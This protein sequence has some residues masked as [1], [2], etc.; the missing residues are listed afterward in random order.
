MSALSTG[1]SKLLAGSAIA[2]A[3]I[4]AGLPQA[5]AT[6][7]SHGA[8]A[9]AA[10][11]RSANGQGTPA[12]DEASLPLKLER[13][14]LENGLRVV[15][16]PDDSSPN[17][18]LSVTY[19]VGSRNERPGLRGF[20]HLFEHLMFQGS[21][22]VQ[23]GD[24][25]RL[26]AAH[27]GRTGSNTT[28]ELT[29]L[30][31]VLPA[32]DLELGL[33]LEADRM[34]SLALSQ[35]KFDGQRRVVQE[36]YRSRV[37]NRAYETGRLRLYQ[38]AFQGYPP[39]ERPAIGAIEDLD[40]ATIAWVRSAFGNYYA[41]NN[42]VLT[43]AGRFD[44]ATAR[45][46]V[47]THFGDI[48]KKTIPEY[49]APPKPRQTSERLSVIEDANA[50]TPGVYYGWLIPPARTA[51]HLALEVASA[52]LARGEGSVLHE[53]LVL[54]KAMAEEISSWTTS[55]R[56]PSLFALRMIMT[57]R[58][59]IDTAQKQLDRELLRLRTRGPRP[60]ELARAKAL[61]SSAFLL[62]L[63]S[64]E[65][66]A[67]LL[68]EYETLWGD[69]RLLDHELERIDQVTADDVRSAA[70]RHLSE[71]QRTIVEVFPPGWT[72]DIFP[73][74]YDRVH[75]VEHGDSL[76]KIARK[77]GVTVAAL[78]KENGIRATTTIFPGQKLIVPV[79]SRRGRTHTVRKGDSLIKI[80]EKYG[81]RVEDITKANK[82]ARKQTLY[83][84]QKLIVPRVSRTLKARGTSHSRAAAAK[85]R[86]HVVKKGDT[87][88]EIAQKY[89]V[90]SGQIR[91]HNKVG[92]KGRIVIGQKLVI[93][94]S[95]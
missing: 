82:I 49:S 75:I 91:A 3:A 85:K 61:L 80:A 73:G 59:T 42:A 14:S 51:D 16:A 72:K 64:N 5:H 47:A 17:V 95:E 56:G 62:D 11:V 18:A 93:P 86:Y 54:Q 20:A 1:R 58:V 71:N 38:L 10:A 43:L 46:L 44:S 83:P 32:S 84:G 25:F 9:P 88:S 34:N 68:G 4:G 27:G 23:Q 21:R 92:P 52:I 57:P 69:A 94:P 89:G 36:E 90:S 53:A 7:P 41:P 26:I 40:G 37:T 6:E 70:A 63:Q 39:Y 22:N 77:Y 67:V 48:R 12:P 50:K 74:I 33:W 31:T 65:R 13:Y 81:V 24:H 60:A 45:Q 87:L 2:I 8:S 29:R 66:R 35:R 76:I 15:L 19:D 55:H 28:T 79:S 78:T 30:T